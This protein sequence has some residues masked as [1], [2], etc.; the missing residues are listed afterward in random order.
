MTEGASAQS[1]ARPTRTTR[2]DLVEAQIYEQAARLF[3]ERGFA[4]TTPQDIADAVGISRQALYYYIKSKDEILARLVSDIS[5][6]ALAAG[7][8]IAA[9]P[10]D[11]PALLR[12]R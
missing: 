8:Q 1:P 5:E 6:Q 3:A 4:A 2:R 12:E 10:L 9:R 11:P 7:R